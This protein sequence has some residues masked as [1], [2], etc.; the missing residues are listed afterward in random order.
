M[1]D[2]PLQSGASAEPSRKDALAGKPSETSRAEPGRAAANHSSSA[3]PSQSHR[4]HSQIAGSPR[5]PQP[6]LE[7]THQPRPPPFD[8]SAMANALPQQP[9]PPQS[10]G[11]GPPRYNAAAMMSPEVVPPMPSAHFGAPP[12]VGPV[13]A[14]QYHVPHH[15]HMS[16]YYPTPLSPQPLAA[17]PP[18]ADL[19][20]Y[21]S[22]FLVNQPPP[23][24]AHY[25]YAPGATFP[26]HAHH[27]QGHFPAGQYGPPNAHQNPPETKPRESQPGRQAANPASVGQQET[28]QYPFPG[29]CENRRVNRPAAL[30][31][32]R[33]HVVR[34]PPRKPRQSGKYNSL[35][36]PS[37]YESITSRTN[38]PL[39]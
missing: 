16:Q 34:G 7:M 1:G 13:P 21:P 25:Y 31:G 2:E 9:Y 15:A 6:Q 22:P 28:G 26:A 36:W 14:Q 39:C 33:Q 11:H 30:S 5:A 12:T 20:Y 32:S 3:P 35:C 37:R 10:Y 18:R 19:A 8:M 4:R 29:V 27:M 38:S 23:P 17:L 24:G